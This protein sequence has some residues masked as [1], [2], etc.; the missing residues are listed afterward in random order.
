MNTE[1]TEDPFLLFLDKEV[2]TLEKLYEG[3]GYMTSYADIMNRGAL[4][5]IKKV[6]E[7]YLSLKQ[8]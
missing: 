6:L 8:Q 4:H 5:Q 7:K 1:T 3:K 2:E